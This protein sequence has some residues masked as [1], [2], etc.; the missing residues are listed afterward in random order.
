MT[1]TPSPKLAFTAYQL[2][3]F[4]TRNYVQHLQ[5]TKQKTSFNE[6]RTN[7]LIF[8]NNKLIIN[9]DMK[10]FPHKAVVISVATSFLAALANKV[11]KNLQQSSISSKLSY[12]LVDGL[13][14]HACI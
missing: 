3:C 8:I 12:N 2:Y 5:H 9:A 7:S 10:N 1:S 6:I 13:L 4:I 14:I 11:M